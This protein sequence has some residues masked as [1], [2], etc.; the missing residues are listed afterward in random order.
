M[1]K[2]HTLH[3]APRQTDEIRYSRGCSTFD[4]VPKQYLADSFQAFAER[5]S[6][7]RV[8]SKGRHISVALSRRECTTDRINMWESVPGESSH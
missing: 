7:T 5:F 8:S 4:N 3:T 2:L 1:T 6:P